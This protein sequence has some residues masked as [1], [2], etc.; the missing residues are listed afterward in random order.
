MNFIAGM[1]FTDLVTDCFWF[2]SDKVGWNFH[3]ANAQC[4]EQDGVLASVKSL[5]QF[6]FLKRAFGNFTYVFLCK[7]KEVY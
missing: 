2:I 5:N 7:F 6:E 3:E 1:C 4:K